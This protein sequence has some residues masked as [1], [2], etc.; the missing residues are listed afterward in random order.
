MTFD[1]R[2]QQN[3]IL[4]DDAGNAVEVVLVDGVYRLRAEVVGTVS[5][6]APAV[7]NLVISGFLENGGSEDMV[8]DGDPTPV[9]FQFDAE[10]GAG[11]E[12]IFLTELRLVFVMSALSWGNFGKSPGGILSNGVL[13]EATIDDGAHVIAL[14]NLT[15]NE[16]FM[17]LDEP[18][19]ELNA[20]SDLISAAFKFSGNEKL[21]KDSGDMVKVTIRDDLTAAPKGIDYFTATLYGFKAAM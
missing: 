13:V 11:A 15:R 4:F 21:V 5:I 18:Y 3:V 17:R 6:G 9:V 12:D 2:A 8:V 14:T 1:N 10:S 7:A 20:G 19:T 16:D